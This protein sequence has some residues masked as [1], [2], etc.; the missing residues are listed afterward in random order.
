MA[1]IGAEVWRYGQRE[2]KVLKQRPH[3]PRVADLEQAGK[4]LAALFLPQYAIDPLTGVLQGRGTGVLGIA[5]AHALAARIG[6]EAQIVGY[7]TPA[8]VVEGLKDGG[9]DLGFLGIEPARATEIDFSPAMFQFDYTYLV[10]AGTA[11]GSVFD[12][13]RP[14]V[15]I[16]VVRNHASTLA[17]SR[18]VKHAEMV[19]SEIPDAAFDLLRTG[20]ADALAFPRDVLLAYAETL[21]GSRVLEDRYGINRVGVAVRKGLTRRLAYI[22][23]FVEEAK[24]SGLI[25]RA[26]ERGGLRGFRVE[27]GGN[28]NT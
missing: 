28:A 13:D 24:A 7:P 10:P 5:I 25:E 2:E 18:I 23:E 22:G 11:I 27:P 6:I 1:G 12:A 20:N 14:G 19:G 4:I 26:I 17:L 16:A 21:P 3:D 15:R 9:C 8:K